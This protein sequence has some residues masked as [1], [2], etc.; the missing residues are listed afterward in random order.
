MKYT[1]RP[2][3]KDSINKLHDLYYNNRRIVLVSPTGSGKTVIAAKIIESAVNSMNNKV[4]FLAHRRELINQCSAKLDEIGIDHGIIMSNHPRS[5]PNSYVQV[6]SVQTLLNRQPPKADFIIIDECHRSLADS[7]KQIVDQYPN[8]PVLGLTATPWRGDG[9]GLGLFYEEMLVVSQVKDLIEEGFLLD[10][11]VHIPHIP[12]LHN[13]KVVGGD[14]VDTEL[15]KIMNQRM[16][17]RQII[18][19]W[20][21]ITP[22][23][24]TVLFA[25]TVDHSLEMVKA[26]N[27]AGVSAEH[28]DCNT[29][30]EERDAILKRLQ[31]GQ[32]TLVSNVGVLTEG[33]DLPELECVLLAR[34]TKSLSLYMQMVGR[35]MRP[36]ESK[37]D[38]IVIDHAGCTQE[39]GL[40]TINRKFDLEG[41][42]VKQAPAYS[43]CPNCM[44]ISKSGRICDV[45]GCTSRPRFVNITREEVKTAGDE[46]F[47]PRCNKCESINLVDV[48]VSNSVKL[49]HGRPSRCRNCGYVT[50]LRRFSSYSADQSAMHLEFQK[51]K[52]IAQEAS[53]GKDW[54]KFKFYEI[55]DR[56]P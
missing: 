1:L 7:Y 56:W 26:F 24:K 23:R 29:S 39:H 42:H 17:N 12:D 19:D 49:T 33:W 25:C 6:A 48:S 43:L 44:R 31:T 9:R 35:G 37:A 15:E 10:P 52:Q 46:V 11:T 8:I 4:L 32:T 2:Y 13:V 45:C 47:M 55:F 14:Y 53:Y 38:T 22:G 50:F 41:E 20:C 54:P 30:T 18:A 16:L 21:S 40:V 5:R 36:H 51:L 27:D 34:P 3:Q 28:L